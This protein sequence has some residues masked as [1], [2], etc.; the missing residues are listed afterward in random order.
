M[1]RP[2]WLIFLAEFAL[3]PASF[4]TEWYDS[5][6]KPS[7]QP[8]GYAFGIAWSLLYPLLLYSY[9]LLIE[10]GQEYDLFLF[11]TQL[12]LNLAWSYTFFTLKNIKLSVLLLVVMIVLNLSLYRV[13]PK[14]WYLLY[15][16]WLSFALV[17]SVSILRLN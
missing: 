15:I 12:A 10:K 11:E 5:L 9:Y 17:L 13:F 16:A 8:P 7:F 3:L 14:P 4:D 6:Q 2:A 1:F